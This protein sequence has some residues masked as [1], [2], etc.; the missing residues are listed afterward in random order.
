VQRAR[1]ASTLEVS[2]EAE[3]R[4]LVSELVVIE[5]VERRSADKVRPDGNR[6]PRHIVQ[7]VLGT[8]SP[9]SKSSRCRGEQDPISAR[10][11]DKAQ[12]DWLE[13][14]TQRLGTMEARLGE[15]AGGDDAPSDDYAQA[16]A[17]GRCWLT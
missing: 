10:P 6:S 9:D 12:K 4:A 8:S 1:E 3:A 11:Y 17:V 2:R 15:K 16:R 14:N 13:E 7:V 5:G